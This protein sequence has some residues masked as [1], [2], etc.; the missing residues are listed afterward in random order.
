MSDELYNSGYHLIGP[1]EWDEDV[2]RVI[3]SLESELSAL[4]KEHKEK[5]SLSSR[6]Q[7]LLKDYTVLVR[8]K[9]ARIAELE[10]VIS[11]LQDE[12]NEALRQLNLKHPKK[13]TYYLM[14]VSDEKWSL[15]P[16]H[17]DIAILFRDRNQNRDLDYRSLT[18]KLTGIYASYRIAIVRTQ[19]PW[20]VIVKQAN[21][22]NHAVDLL[23][24]QP[25]IAYVDWSAELKKWAEKKQ[26]LD[27]IERLSASRTQLIEE[28]KWAWQSSHKHEEQ[29]K[30]AHKKYQDTLAE[31]NRLKNNHHSLKTKVGASDC[32][33][34]RKTL[35]NKSG[36]DQ[37]L[38]DTV[39]GELNELKIVDNTCPGCKKSFSSPGAVKDHM[40]MTHIGPS[41]TKS[42]VDKMQISGVYQDRLPRPSFEQA[43]KLQQ[44]SSDDFKGLPRKKKTQ[45]EMAWV[46][47]SCQCQSMHC[48]EHW[49]GHPC[50]QSAVREVYGFGMGVRIKACQACA[51]GYCDASGGLLKQRCGCG[52]CK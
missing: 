6:R 2:H 51:N 42:C 24:M 27:K 50:S 3:D 17:Q 9:N 39:C 28:I 21:Q 13:P 43:I 30:I 15:L 5:M 41:L 31:L 34:C 11:N 12:R 35:A 44:M 8:N 25:G 22:I 52:E 49:A 29:F 37:H 18:Q 23:H 47:N 7:E 33:V 14:R 19:E 38:R 32:P 20:D 40:R 1:Q 46:R 48:K 45:H 26:L 10:L 36:R 4:K 16:Y